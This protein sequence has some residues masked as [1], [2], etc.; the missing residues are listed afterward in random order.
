MSVT[1]DFWPEKCSSNRWDFIFPS[2]LKNSKKEFM[3]AKWKQSIDEVIDGAIQSCPIDTR[4]KLYE[5]VVLSGGSSLIK[6]LDKRLK[7]EL[8]VCQNLNFQTIFFNIEKSQRQIAKIQGKNGNGG[9]LK[10]FFNVFFA[11]FLQSPKKSM[12]ISST[13]LIRNIRFCKEEV[14]WPQMYFFFI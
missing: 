12:L 6:G 13:T 9:N 10:Q 1:R 8:Q 3:D 2:F 4:R 11:I 7:L 5:N 14:W